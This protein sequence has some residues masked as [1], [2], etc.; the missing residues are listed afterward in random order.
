MSEMIFANRNQI[1]FWGVMKIFEGMI[2]YDFI[3][4][5]CCQKLQK[6]GLGRLGRSSLPKF[7]A[8]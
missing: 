5:S 8:Q 3:K 2:S 7:Q 4:I 1:E 6:V